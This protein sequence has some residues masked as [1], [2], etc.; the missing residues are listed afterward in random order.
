MNK[1]FTKALIIYHS[2]DLDG[3]FSGS[4]LK[5]YYEQNYNFIKTVPYN[6]ETEGVEF[7]NKQKDYV[8]YYDIII[9]VDLTPSAEWLKNYNDIIL[10]DVSIKNKKLLII[11]HHKNKVDE[12]LE[13]VK[14]NNNIQQVQYSSIF[15][16]QHNKNINEYVHNKN[17]ENYIYNVG[18]ENL[19][20]NIEFILSLKSESNLM[21]SATMLTYLY[22]IKLDVDNYDFYVNIWNYMFFIS[23]YDVWN[24]NEEGYN[25]FTKQEIIWFQYGMFSIIENDINNGNFEY[26]LKYLFNTYLV[27]PNYINSIIEKGKKIYDDKISIMDL[28]S[29]YHLV[30][31]KFII[32][33]GDFPEFVLQ[34]YLKNK[35][36]DFNIEALIF[37][38]F[39][40]DENQ[41]SLS[42]RQCHN[43]KF[44]CINF[45]KYLTNNNGGGHFA[46]SGGSVEYNEHNNLL[47]RI[48][49][50]M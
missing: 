44:D 6:Y 1:K 28:K 41:I 18:D 48:Y 42:I 17:Y 3:I 40:F 46:A 43:R 24:F 12:L 13:V 26:I 47:Q 45:V 20:L 14:S 29:N 25:V 35:F 19:S 31:D 49:K 23:E 32:I 22:L 34:E 38:K 5:N 8:Y 11:D 2:K 10:K 33:Y 4:L 30:N 21:M 16:F 36:I 15:N 50:Y 27:N 7:I 9:F 39:K 37:L